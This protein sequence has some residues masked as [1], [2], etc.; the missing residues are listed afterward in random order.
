ML[1]TYLFPFPFSPEVGDGG[2]VV[3]EH[4]F[5]AIGSGDLNG[6]ECLDESG[7]D[8]FRQNVL[9]IKKLI[10]IFSLRAQ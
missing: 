7:C 6:G 9:K 2:G 8:L 1:L 4:L 10:T 5:L 3:L